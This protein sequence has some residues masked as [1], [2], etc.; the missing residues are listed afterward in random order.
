[1]LGAGGN[2]DR[3]NTTIQGIGIV[4]GQ[5]RPFVSFLAKNWPLA[6]IAGIA[7]Y[8]KVSERRK[9]REL[10]AYNTFTDLGLILS[11]LVSLA[12][13]NQLAQAE[14]AKLNGLPSPSPIPG[15]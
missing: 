13:L 12:V 8:S 4:A 10:T 7:M 1:M 2:I 9:K 3:L 6:V 5:N 11:P 14:H 15:A